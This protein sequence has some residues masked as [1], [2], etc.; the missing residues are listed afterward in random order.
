MWLDHRPPDRAASSRSEKV[1]YVQY[2]GATP[3]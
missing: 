3:M 2:G 1:S